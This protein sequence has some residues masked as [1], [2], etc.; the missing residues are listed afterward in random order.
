MSSSEFNE[1]GQAIN[2]HRGINE[3]AVTI[4]I[5]DVWMFK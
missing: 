5:T 2:I 3:K 4:S 1:D